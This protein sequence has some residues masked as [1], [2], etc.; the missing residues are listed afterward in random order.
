MHFLLTCITGEGN[1]ASEVAT[2]ASF[3]D[4]GGVKMKAT[5]KK[6]SN[7][8]KTTKERLNMIDGL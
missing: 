5:P 8:K 3:E 2:P 6:R 4:Q 7:K 1:F